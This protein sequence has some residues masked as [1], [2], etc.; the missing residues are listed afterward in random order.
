MVI[1]RDCEQRHVDTADLRDVITKGVGLA[2]ATIIQAGWPHVTPEADQ[3]HAAEATSAA[4]VAAIPV[5]AANGRVLGCISSVTLLTV[6]TREHRE[7]L[8]RLAGILHERSGA[9]HALED[10]PLQRMVRRVPWLLVGLALS[11]AAA[12]VM[13][14]YEEALRANVKNPI[15]RFRWLRAPQ[16]FLLTLR[17]AEPR[18]PLT[19]RIVGCEPPI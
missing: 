1:V 4:C 18:V 17:Y 19:A 12:G 2:L 13:A 11:T 5:V 15:G 14:A 6:L 7:D 9:R 16:L 10:P 8:H 3:E